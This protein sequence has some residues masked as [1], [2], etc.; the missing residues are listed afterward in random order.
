MTDVCPIRHMDSDNRREL[1]EHC[2]ISR[3]LTVWSDVSELPP[4]IQEAANRC[5]VWCVP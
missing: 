4:T 1:A 3:R 5:E 2:V